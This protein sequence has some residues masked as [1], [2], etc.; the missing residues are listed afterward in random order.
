MLG[1]SV[2][3]PKRAAAEPSPQT[4]R[5]RAPSALAFP[6]DVAPEAILA[7][8][9]DLDQIDAVARVAL[10]LSII[11]VSTTVN[12]FSFWDEHMRELK[13]TS[14]TGLFQCKD[15]DRVRVAGIVVARARPPT[16]SGKTAIFITLEDASGLVDV[17][18]FEECYQRCGRALYSS[19]VLCV[20]GKL[21]RQGALDL[22]V[23]AQSVIALGS[24]RDFTRPTKR[25]APR[26]PQAADKSGKLVHTGEA[27][28]LQNKTMAPWEPRPNP[29]VG[30]RRG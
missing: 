5:S 1:A 25:P 2:K 29:K 30:D 14:S 13:V 21:T 28:G 26:A 9:P 6:E 4:T 12:A 27:W 16:R 15:G 18:V 3:T 19:P 22:S 7:T 11:G 17:A 8:L 10:D 24:W 20:E 23:T